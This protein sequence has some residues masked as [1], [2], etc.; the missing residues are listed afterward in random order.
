MIR[1]IMKFFDSLDRGVIRK[2]EQRELPPID[3]PNAS[4]DFN[5]FFGFFFDGTRNNYNLCTENEG[6]S[7][8]ARLYD[9][10]PGQA[11]PGAK[12]HCLWTGVKIIP[13]SSTCIFR[14]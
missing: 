11:E 8:V 9:T 5:L 6:F 12:K 2:Y 13:A 10:Y 14:T 4:C 7:N 3:N 1:A